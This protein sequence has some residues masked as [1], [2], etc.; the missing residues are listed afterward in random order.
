M[1]IMNRVFDRL[2]YT[3]NNKMTQYD[4]DKFMNGTLKLAIAAVAEMNLISESDYIEIHNKL[5]YMSDDLKI[6]NNFLKNI[7]IQV[8]NNPMSINRYRGGKKK[9]TTKQKKSLNKSKKNKSRR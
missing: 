7:L 1:T 3:K 8:R 2:N 6:Q 5:L 9:K 4:S